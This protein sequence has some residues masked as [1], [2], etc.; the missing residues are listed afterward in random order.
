MVNTTRGPGWVL[1]NQ[2]DPLVGFDSLARWAGTRKVKSVAMWCARNR[3]KTFR[4]TKKRPCT[5]L[6][7]INEALNGGRRENVEPN[8][9]SLP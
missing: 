6:D 4:D 5:T 1:P 8:Y 3:I 9:V 2:I 7:A